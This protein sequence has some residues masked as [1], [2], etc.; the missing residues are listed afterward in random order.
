MRAM[1]PAHRFRHVAHGAKTESDNV[2]LSGGY[3][4][5]PPRAVW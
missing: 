4:F 1:S 3:I 2:A 5:S